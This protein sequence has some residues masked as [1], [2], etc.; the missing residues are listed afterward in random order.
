VHPDEKPR[1][2]EHP[3]EGEDAAGAGAGAH[4]AIECDEQR[5][6]R[7]PGQPAERSL[8]E[9]GAEQSARQQRERARRPVSRGGPLSP[10][11][12]TGRWR[13]SGA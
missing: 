4:R 2:T 7:E 10:A 6:E 8:E 12:R 11:P 5:D 3:A 13:P 1:E 9:R